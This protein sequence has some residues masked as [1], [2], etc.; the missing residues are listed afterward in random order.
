MTRKPTTKIELWPPGA[1]VSITREVYD[2]EIVEV[3]LRGE[4]LNIEY[5]VA[6]W[7][8]HTRLLQRFRPDQIGTHEQA[9]HAPQLAI[10]FHARAE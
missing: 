5:L 7:D 1:K 2:A 4:P 6:W 10:G 8:G 9:P 3:V